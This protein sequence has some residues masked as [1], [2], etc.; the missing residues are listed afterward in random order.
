MEM[1]RTLIAVIAL[2]YICLYVL[3]VVTVN[4]FFA[5]ICLNRDLMLDIH[6]L[7]PLLCDEIREFYKELNI[8]IKG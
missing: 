5:I 8:Y 4:L 6:D 3:C 7:I 2:L 1:I